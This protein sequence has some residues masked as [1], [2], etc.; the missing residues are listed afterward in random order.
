MSRAPL[1]R[2]SV[3]GT[4]TLTTRIIHGTYLL[5]TKRSTKTGLQ[6]RALYPV[7]IADPC[8]Q[9]K[10]PKVQVLRNVATDPLANNAVPATAS[11]DPRSSIL[12]Q[13]ASPVLIVEIPT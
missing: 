9:A 12:R 8:L 6:R 7:E 1:Y 3:S 13:A 5:S 4:Q 11:Q 2:R 10:T